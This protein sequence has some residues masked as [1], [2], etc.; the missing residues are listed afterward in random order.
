MTELA[1]LNS[2]RDHEGT[3]VRKP[4]QYPVTATLAHLETPDSLEMVVALLRAQIL[5]PYIVVVDTG[6]TRDT[7]RRLERM[8]ADDLEV[9]YL[10]GH[11][12]QHASEPIAAACDL[13]M[14]TCRTEFLF[15]TQTDVFP[16]RRDLL[17]DLVTLAADHK[18]VGYEMSP[19]DWVTDRWRGMVGHTATMLHMP[20]M[21]R[22]GA[23]WDMQRGVES[24]DLPYLRP[25]QGWPDTETT[26]NEILAEHGIKP[27]FIGH[28]ENAT[29][30]VDANLR[31]CRSYGVTTVYGGANGQQ[32]WVAD[33]LEEARENLRRWSR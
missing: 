18:V 11:A 33:A 32:R 8:R 13:A 12:W 9:H 5:A 17:A 3:I 10:R 31:H 20:T 22:I 6:S 14:V 4:W 23:Q 28:D 25:A 29:N 16:Q 24:Y 7:C 27:H 21:R 2:R 19:R 26:F 1:P 30:Y 15:L